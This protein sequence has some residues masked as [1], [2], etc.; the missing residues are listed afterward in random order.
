MEIADLHTILRLPT[1]IFYAKGVKANVL[2]FDN[3]GAPKTHGPKMC[4]SL[5]T[6]LTFT[7]L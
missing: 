3:K 5:T 7:I 6:G 2:F 4:G 1:G